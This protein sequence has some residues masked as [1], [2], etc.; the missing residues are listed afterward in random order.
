MSEET[1]NTEFTVFEM[2]PGC[3][4]E[5][6]GEEHCWYWAPVAFK[7]KTQK[8][9]NKMREKVYKKFAKFIA[10]NVSTFKTS[11]WKYINR[12][13]FI[14]VENKPIIKKE[15][16]KAVPVLEYVDLFGQTQQIMSN[17][18]ERLKPICK[19]E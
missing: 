6:N 2:R 19:G 13:D 18:K 1:K 11:D 14:M 15:H 8:D 12:I 4:Y 7:V 3:N 5:F 10:L 17:G 9:I 16:K